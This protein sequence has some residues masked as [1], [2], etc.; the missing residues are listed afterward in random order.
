MQGPWQRYL[1]T[2]KNIQ[3]Q[4]IKMTKRLRNFAG[5]HES[6]D[7]IEPVTLRFAPIPRT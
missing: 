4:R 1:L 5:G 3:S 6:F 7:S 2:T